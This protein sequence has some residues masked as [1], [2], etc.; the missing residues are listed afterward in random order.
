MKKP[1]SLVLL[2]VVILTASISLGGIWWRMWMYHGWIGSPHLLSSLMSMDG[3]GSYQAIMIEMMLISFVIIVA[4]L[5]VFQFLRKRK[6][7]G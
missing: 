2:V 3:E 4:G 7:P 6:K 1:A 5:G